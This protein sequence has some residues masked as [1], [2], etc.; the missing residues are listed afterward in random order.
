MAKPRKGVSK[1]NR[2]CGLCKP[3]RAE[4]NGGTKAKYKETARHG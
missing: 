3:H 2:A 1:R 4:G